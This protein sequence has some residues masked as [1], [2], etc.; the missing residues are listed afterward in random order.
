MRTTLL[1]VPV[2]FAALLL[3][4]ADALAHG[5]TY[6]GPGS[7]QPPSLVCDCAKIECPHCTSRQ[8]VESRGISRRVADHRVVKRWDDLIQVRST[9]RFESSRKQFVE[10]YATL[11]HA[12]LF[13]ATA[14]RIRVGKDELKGVMKASVKAR[15]DYLWERQGNRDPLL[16]LRKDASSVTLRA[17]PISKSASTWAVVEGFAL[18]DAIGGRGLRLYRTKDRYLAIVSTADVAKGVKPDFVD[19]GGQRALFFLD[20]KVAQKRYG[21]AT[22]KAREVPCVA[23][24][25]SAVRNHGVDA[26]TKHAGLVAIPRGRGAPKNLTVGHGDDPVPPPPPPSPTAPAVPPEAVTPPTPPQG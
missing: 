16:V 24:L 5:G 6:R 17:F 8:L 20:A 14:G 23:A 22:T 4:A 10:G 15:R 7:W 1:V 26:V 25:E 21:A 2:F 3:S 19:V 13:A 12:P 18:S 11:Q 9:V